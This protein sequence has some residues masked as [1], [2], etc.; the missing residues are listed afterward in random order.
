MR[1]AANMIKNGGVCGLSTTQTTT[2]KTT[3]R[4][5]AAALSL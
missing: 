3:M 4:T 1:T 2:E 5:A